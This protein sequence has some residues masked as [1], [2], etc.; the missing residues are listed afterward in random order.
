M[1]ASGSSSQSSTADELAIGAAVVVA[2]DEVMALTT[3]V[4]NLE[5]VVSGSSS[6]SSPSSTGADVVAGAA[7]E[8]TAVEAAGFTIEVT[9]VVGAAVETGAA[10]D[11]GAT[12]DDAA[13]EDETGAA[14]PDPPMVKSM[15]DSYVWE[16]EAAFQNHWMTQSPRQS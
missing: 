12:A 7:A 8:E 1:V 16:M 5:D 2:L 4:T 11:V 15:Q 14:E 6:Q 3:E 10:E 9:M 13:D